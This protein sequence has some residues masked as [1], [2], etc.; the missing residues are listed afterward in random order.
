MST[1]LT[2]RWGDSIT[3]PTEAQCIVVL[4]ELADADDGDTDAAADRAEHGEVSLSWW[5]GENDWSIATDGRGKTIF[6][7]LV[8]PDER[9][10]AYDLP[11]PT[12][13]EHVLAL[14]HLLRLGDLAAIRR[15]PWRPLRT[16]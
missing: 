16:S 13:V 5:D 6:G 3:D 1:T 15:L 11:E 2:D 9:E 4:R 7:G 14:W 8:G 12:T 10:E